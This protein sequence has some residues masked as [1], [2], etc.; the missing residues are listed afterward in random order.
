MLPAVALTHRVPGFS[1]QAFEGP[2]EAILLSAVLQQLICHAGLL[3]SGRGAGRLGQ[4][5]VQPGERRDQVIDPGTAQG[6]EGRRK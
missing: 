4:G 1:A 3:G 6:R 2:G 5:L